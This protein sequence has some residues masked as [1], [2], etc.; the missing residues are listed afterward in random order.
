MQAKRNQNNFV[1]RKVYHDID[2]NQKF[3]KH[4][5]NIFDK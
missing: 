3:V 5:I 1:T 4:I 2:L